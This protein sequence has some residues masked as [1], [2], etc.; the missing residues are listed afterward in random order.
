MATRIVRLGKCSDC[1]GQAQVS[2]IGLVM[3]NSNIHIG[4]HVPSTLTLAPSFFS[5][6]RTRHS[7]I[8][9]WVIIRRASVRK[10][11]Q[12]GHIPNFLRLKLLIILL[13]IGFRKF[14]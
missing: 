8:S 1:S 2:R 3:K 11:C 13:T 10:F 6:G 7:V 4:T 14:A 5:Y 12:I 9:I